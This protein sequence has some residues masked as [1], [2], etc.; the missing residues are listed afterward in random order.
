MVFDFTSTN[1]LSLNI[2]IPSSFPF[3]L[4]DIS[5]PKFLQN[6]LWLVFFLAKYPFICLDNF[7][8]L[9]LKKPTFIAL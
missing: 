4:I 8:F 9:I 6:F 3:I 5:Y 1:F 2:S 7:E